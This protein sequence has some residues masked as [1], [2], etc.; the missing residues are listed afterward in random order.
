MND[1]TEEPK[2]I[3]NSIVQS[4]RDWTDDERSAIVFEIVY[5]GYRKS[6]TSRLDFV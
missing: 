6:P 4:D 5:H 1:P 3:N 2:P